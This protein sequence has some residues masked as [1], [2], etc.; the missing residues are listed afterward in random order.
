MESIYADRLD[1]LFSLLA[2]HFALA[3]EHAKAIEY[4]RKAAKQAVALFAYDDAIQNLRGAL[5]LI[6]AGRQ[7]ENSYHPARGIGGCLPPPSRHWA[8]DRFLSRLSAPLGNP[9]GE[10]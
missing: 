4:S 1:G 10:G 6:E 9:A 5:E 2:Y 8:G 7:V 3:D